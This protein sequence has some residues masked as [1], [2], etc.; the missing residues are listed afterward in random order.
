MNIWDDVKINLPLW[1]LLVL[2]FVLSSFLSSLIPMSDWWDD[3]TLW[4]VC[5]TSSS[6][7]YLMTLDSSSPCDV[8]GVIVGVHH[9]NHSLPNIHNT[10]MSSCVK[11]VVN[12][13]MTCLL[14]SV[15]NLIFLL[16]PDGIRL[17]FP[18][19]CLWCGCWNLCPWMKRQTN[20]TQMTPSSLLLLCEWRSSCHTLTS[21][22][23]IK[24]EFISQHTFI[25]FNIFILSDF[26][27]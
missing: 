20:H 18:L 17:L 2:L 22:P 8:N 15:I 4:W 27:I 16:L 7:F 14:S 26:N 24:C 23:M 1:S 5:W 21:F 3:F 19:W 9:A 6:S 25:H 12:D 10:R 13:E 11:C